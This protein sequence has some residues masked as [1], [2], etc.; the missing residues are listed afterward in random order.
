MISVRGNK[1][2]IVIIRCRRNTTTNLRFLVCLHY[3]DSSIPFAF[4]A[5]NRG[6]MTG[7][8]IS[9]GIAIAYLDHW[10]AF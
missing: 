7:V 6:A 5:G 2:R 1:Q 10:H 9:F 3:G 8:G 4:V